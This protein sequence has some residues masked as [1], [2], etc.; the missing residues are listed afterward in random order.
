MSPATVGRGVRVKQILDDMKQSQ[1]HDE[2]GVSDALKFPCV[3]SRIPILL[4]SPV[5]ALHIIIPHNRH[6]DEL[7]RAACPVRR[8][9]S[10][11]CPVRRIAEE[12]CHQCS[13]VEL[14]VLAIGAIGGTVE[15]LYN[16]VGAPYS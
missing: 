7:L 9:G 4:A 11:W 16:S 15:V 1:L 13:A 12:W 3:M 5:A 2:L 14:P 8:E 10:K 6:L